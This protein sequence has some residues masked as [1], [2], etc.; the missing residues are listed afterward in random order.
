M[1]NGL[2]GV[3]QEWDEER[4]CWTVRLYDGT[5]RALRPENIYLVPQCAPPQET[6]VIPVGISDPVQPS[7]PFWQ[8]RDGATA[9]L[10]NLQDFPKLNGQEVTIERFS[11]Q[12]N[13]WAVLLSNGD[14]CAVKIQH[15]APPSHGLVGEAVDPALAGLTSVTLPP[16][17]ANAAASEAL[18]LQLQATPSAVAPGQLVQIV[19][20]QNMPHFNGQHATITAIGENGCY[21][22]LLPDVVVAE[23]APPQP[24]SVRIR[25]ENILPL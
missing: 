15:L 11:P 13:C 19:G 9:R 12:G 20:L 5:V 14:R 23:G 2:D 25:S 4:G 7:A 16:A 8:P 6:S 18:D 10:H 1:G 21:Q 24:H 22:V 3:L 17:H